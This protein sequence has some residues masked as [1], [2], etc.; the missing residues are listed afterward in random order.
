[1][2]RA[3]SCSTGFSAATAL[4]LPLREVG[5]AIRIESNVYNGLL[6]DDFV[7]TELGTE[8][9]AELQAGYDAVH[10]GEGNFGSG[11]AAVDGDAAHI[12]LRAKRSGMDAADFHA[13]AGDALHFGDEAAANHRLE[14]IG[15]DV[16]RAGRASDKNDCGGKISRYFHQR[17]RSGLV[18]GSVTAIALP[19][20][21]PR[22]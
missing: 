11:F 5:G 14:G 6:E 4:G 3:K 15:V 9:R 22:A 2:E 16:D 17:R 18:E 7:K 19:G 20:R 8:Q 1:M 13:A 10:V 12:D 21:W